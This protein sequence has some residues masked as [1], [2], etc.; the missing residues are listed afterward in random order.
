MRRGHREKVATVAEEVNKR[1][2][3][4]RWA[5]EKLRY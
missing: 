2:G 5:G 4:K 1:G 3:E